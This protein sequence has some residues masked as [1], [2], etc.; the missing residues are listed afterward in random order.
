MLSP[1][2]GTK[3]SEKDIIIAQSPLSETIV[4]K[5]DCIDALISLG[6]RLSLVKMPNVI[7]KSLDE[8]VFIIER[9][10]MSIERIN[11]KNDNTTAQDNP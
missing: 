1:G 11:K 6:K 8:G 7:H 10:N 9:E 3:E 2:C 4:K 5:G